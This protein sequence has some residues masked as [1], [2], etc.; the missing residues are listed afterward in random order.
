[1]W[2]EKKKKVGAGER[3]LFD[4]ET[5]CEKADKGKGGFSS[6]T[7]PFPQPVHFWWWCREI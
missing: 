1:M 6:P 4:K 5:R 7:K 2:Q 3:L